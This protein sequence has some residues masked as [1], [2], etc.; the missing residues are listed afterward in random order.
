MVLVFKMF[1]SYC[2]ERVSEKANKRC[3]VEC[4]E[5]GN[6]KTHLMRIVS[7]EFFFNY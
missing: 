7:K 5:Y 6:F 3:M 4:L 1:L 2:D